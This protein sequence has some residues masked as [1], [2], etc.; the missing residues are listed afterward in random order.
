MLSMK[1]EPSNS[2]FQD[3]TW[4]GLW[5]HYYILSKFHSTFIHAACLVKTLLW[6]K[7]YKLLLVMVV[8]IVVVVIAV[9]IIDPFF[10]SC[11]GVFS[12]LKCIDRSMLLRNGSLR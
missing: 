9:L 11:L 3:P 8:V 5:M 12:S 10:D 7:K 4:F 1:S 2:I 6:Q